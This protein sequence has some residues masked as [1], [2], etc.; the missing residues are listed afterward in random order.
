MESEISSAEEQLR[1]AMLASDVESLE[2]LISPDLV[3]VTHFGAVLSKQDDLELH[4]SGALRFH[5]IDP[6]ERRDLML[7]QAAYVSV[8]VH[9][10]GVFNGSPFQDDFQFSRL[11]QR[12]E[13]GAWQ[14]IAGQATVVQALAHPPS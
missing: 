2:A 13:N 11:W 10:S 14:V 4:R 8:R 9:L 6:S 3:F 1:L 5:C 7:D 12:N